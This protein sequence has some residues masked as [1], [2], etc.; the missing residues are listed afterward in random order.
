[1]ASI[2]R[3]DKRLSSR[4]EFLQALYAEAPED[5]YLELRCI[6][7]ATGEVRPLWSRIGNKR[8]LSS[9]F[10]QADALNSEGFGVF[11]A[12]C[13]RREKSGKADSA[14]LA[15]AFWID[16]DSTAPDNLESLRSFDPASS[17]IISSGG[18]WHAYWLLEEPFQLED[19]AS[20]Q[21]FATILRG[22]FTLLDGDPAYVKSPASTM[23]LPD[24]VNTKPNRSDA[25]VSIIEAHPDRRYPFERFEWLDVQPQPE[26]VGS[27]TVV[28]VNGNGHHP[29]PPRTE[30][31]LTSGAPNG[32]RN[33]ELFA[34]A[35]QLRDAGHS[36][37]EAEKELIPRHIAN[38]SS[39]REAQAT[40]ESAYSRPPREPISQPLDQ[41]QERIEALVSRY[42]RSS[43]ESEH[44]TAAQ[45]REAVKACA[46]LDSLEWAE[47]R[48]RLKA[49][50]GDVFKT[51]DLNQMYRQARRELER[52]E[53]PNLL[54]SPR[55][56]VQ[57][58][59]IALEKPSERGT[60]RQ[61]VT[62]WSGRIV[63]WLVQVNDDGQS[64]N[65]MRVTLQHHTH[66]TTLDIASELFGDP[67]AFQRFIAQKAGGIYTVHAGMTKHLPSAINQLSGEY[68]TRTTYRF[69]GWTQIDERW[70][71]ISPS[72]SIDAEGVVASPPEVEL[73]SRLR[74]YRL[75]DEL[76]EDGLV[77]LKAAMGVFPQ[78]LAPSLLA[79]A[80]LPLLQ[81]FFPAAAPKPALHLV[82]TTGS[83]K[84]EI[85][86][87]MSSFYGAFTRD[88]P[89]AQW[90]DTVN[91]VEALGYSLADALY[92]VDDYKSCYA[93]ER[94][95]TRFLQSYSR[96]MGRGRLT[97][98]AKLRQER[99]CRGLLLSTGETTIE[100]EASILSRML[101]LEVP[102]W[103][104]RDP[105]GKLL[106]QAEALRH[107]LPA[108][109]AHFAAWVA[110]QIEDETFQ[111]DLAMRFAAN[112]QGYREKLAATNVGQ[113]NTGRVLQNW[114]VLV[115]VYQLLSQFFR[116]VDAEYLL[117]DW[118]DTL[119]DTI[120][121]FRQER[122][123]EVFLDILSQLI[124]GGQAV[125][126]DNMNN[127][128]DYPSGVAV[129]GYRDGNY[130]YLLPEIARREVDRVQALR[131]TTTAIGQQL[132]E[133][134]VLLSSGSSLAVQKRVKGGRA[135]F[136]QLKSDVLGCDTSD[137]RDSA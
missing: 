72:V 10:K 88:T 81:R 2:E 109:T 59:G 64:E 30:Q 123:S 118:S 135:R 16:V 23:R 3:D 11:F 25:L 42:S 17:Y 110:K 46:A 99:P 5:L 119:G 55:Y 136:W 49:V 116:S 40:I 6:H 13:L 26:Q 50:C 39:E 127:P 106:I 29:L 68:P 131:F 56:V 58:G 102:P 122:A 32:S 129:I 93:D 105:G 22:L 34:A 126:D 60:M 90:G 86:A 8:Q 111:R 121:R 44:P 73:E 134:G 97:R 12:P 80:M 94:T 137:T 76:W 71:Y 52:A 95:F 37:A 7:P 21:T 27:L 65:S 77:A 82:G 19:D 36:Q 31:Y 113:S 63:E 84:S 100:G 20:R 125:I 74:D 47:Q 115:T 75:Q 132:R 1:M 114:A 54:S 14:V 35:C 92:W 28:T 104:R 112:V 24:S 128:S 78:A 130:I 98:E 18:G 70:V 57:D 101:V 108:F 96:G 67:N 69:M 107:Y 33:A 133:D 117:P 51:D 66:S 45:I 62:D 9:I 38:G 48:K 53:Q 87:I 103:E 120:S 91:T 43:A 89:P 15:P 4:R 61:Q 83:G 79:F 85:A 124:A 41:A